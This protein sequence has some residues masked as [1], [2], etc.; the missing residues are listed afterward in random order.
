MLKLFQKTVLKETYDQLFND[1]NELNKSRTRLQE[2]VI[3]L[4]SQILDMQACEEVLRTARDKEAAQKNRF[5]EEAREEVQ[6]WK[7]E[8]EEVLASADK[9][10]AKLEKLVKTNKKTKK[11]VKR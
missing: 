4:N 7:K 6:Y 8:Y 11:A 10:I 9:E 2:Q 5:L 3:N 1:Y